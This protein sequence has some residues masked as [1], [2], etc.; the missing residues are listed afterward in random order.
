MSGHL[1]AASFQKVGSAY[2][3]SAFKNPIGNAHWIILFV[4]HRPSSLQI[5]LVRRRH[6]DFSRL[7][8]ADTREPPE[9]LLVLVAG[10]LG[11]TS[12]LLRPLQTPV[13][14]ALPVS[15]IAA[16]LSALAKAH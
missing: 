15:L 5:L 4:L 7:T 9:Q 3:L 2:Y 11:A 8:F 1:S 14:P 13:W 12:T 6:E 10:R 16:V